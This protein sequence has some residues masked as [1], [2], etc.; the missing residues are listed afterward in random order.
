MSVKIHHGAPGS[1][2]T[3]GA[4]ADD[5]PAAVIAGRHIITNVRGLHDRDLIASVIGLKFKKDIPESFKITYIKTDPSD[6]SEEF[7]DQSC[8]ENM[9]ML[10]RFWH[11][12]PDGA[13]FILDE[14]QEIY[15]KTF[16]DR[17]LKKLEYP[18]GIEAANR[19]GKFLTIALAFEKHR[20]RNWDFIVTTPNISKVHDVV[21]SVADGA[22]KHKNL[23]ILGGMFKGRYVEGFHSGDTSGRPADFNSV[24]RKKIPN[25]VFDLYKS[26]ATGVVSDTR[27]GQS[28]FKNPKILGLLIFLSLIIG[29]LVYLPSFNLHGNTPAKTPVAVP[30]QPAGVGNSQIVHND[31]AVVPAPVVTKL[32]SLPPELQF[33][34]RPNPVLSGSGHITWSSD[35]DLYSI[36][37]IDDTGT[38]TLT[39][40]MAVALGLKVFIIDN[41]MA[42]VIR[43]GEVVAIAFAAPKRYE[44]AKESVITPV[45]SLTLP[46]TQQ[47]AV[48]VGGANLPKSLSN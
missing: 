30:A 19:D 40:K 26:T 38:V 17:D 5:L 25:Y 14:I 46:V 44:E 43:K 27:S 31:V 36:D 9:E 35:Y 8:S 18:G 3:S 13:F 28:L 48:T 6:L 12:S 16:K 22:Y 39:P 37:F 45:S 4:I 11:W 1:Y 23:A 33:L 41:R 47:T 21:R 2:K 10:R 15:P 34:S 24:I 32:T 7:Q 29:V 20:H 42:K